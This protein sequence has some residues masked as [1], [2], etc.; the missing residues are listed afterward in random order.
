MNYNRIECAVFSLMNRF[1]LDDFFP[2]C[3]KWFKQVTELIESGGIDRA[4][5]FICILFLVCC[6]YFIR[7][8]WYHEARSHYHEQRAFEKKTAVESSSESYDVGIAKRL[9]DVSVELTNLE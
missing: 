7:F 9:W 6:T 4:L 8:I 1:K 2:A 3:T 5:L